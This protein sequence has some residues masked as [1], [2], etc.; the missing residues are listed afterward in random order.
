[1]W[2]L[3]D[4]DAEVVRRVLRR[5][6]FRDVGERR[7]DGFAVEGA[8]ASEDGDQPL[9]VAYC[10]N[11][12][13]TATLDRYRRVL[14]RAGLRVGDDPHGLGLLVDRRSVASVHRVP[15]SGRPLLTA[16]IICA[17]FATVALVVSW[18]ADGHVRLAGGI[19]S[20]VLGCL[21][22]GLAALWYRRQPDEQQHGTRSM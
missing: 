13:A 20:G 22:V 10:G 16:A 9:A 5:A 2:S 19:G 7:V 6:G 15:W 12:E 4:R 18:M 8:N 11:A 3:R 14:Q 21:A 1:M 17:V